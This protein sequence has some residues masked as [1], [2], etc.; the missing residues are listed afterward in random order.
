MTPSKVF[1]EID[2]TTQSRKGG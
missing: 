1:N 2:S